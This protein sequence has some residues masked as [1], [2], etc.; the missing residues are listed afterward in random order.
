MFYLELFWLELG[1]QGLQAIGVSN[2][3]A[4]TVGAL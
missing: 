3:L 2:A 1:P 4:V